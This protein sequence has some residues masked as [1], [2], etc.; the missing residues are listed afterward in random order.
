MTDLDTSKYQNDADY[1]NRNVETVEDAEKMMS[2]SDLVSSAVKHLAS[3]GSEYNDAPTKTAAGVTSLA[4]DLARGRKSYRH[5]AGA[6]D[7]CDLAMQQ[8]YSTKAQ[9]EE[10]IAALQAEL[11]DIN[12]VI[13][14]LNAMQEA[15]G[16]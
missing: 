15:M 6:K 16:Q 11:A 10:R 9:I 8:A 14:G 13:V 1:K 3:I 5:T 2:A 7:E 12:V 4:A